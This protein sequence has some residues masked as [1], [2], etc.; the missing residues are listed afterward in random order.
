MSEPSPSGSKPLRT[1]YIGHD[2]V[3][4][5]LRSQG[6]SGW[7]TPQSLQQ[8]LHRMDEF[9]RDLPA[10]AGAS[11]LEL[12]CGAGDLMLHWAAKGW[13]VCGVDIAPFAI[14]WAQEKSARLGVQAELFVGDVTT[15]L[16]LPVP[17]VD[18]VLDGHCLHCIIGPDRPAFYANA[19]KFLK[20]GGI[21][22]LNTMCGEP[23]PHN[24]KGYDPHTRCILFA[25]GRAVR[26]F[27]LPQAILAEVTQAGF[28]IVKSAVLPAEDEDDEDCL[29]VNAVKV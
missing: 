21:L 3:Y 14:A 1:N 4:V 16:H 7:D 23:H 2:A 24:R 17:P 22:H 8:T 12:G 29:L 28:R 10:P 18:L 13:R 27:G 19:Y 9:L 20:P 5:R 15:D 26:Y 11:L 25:D 6:R